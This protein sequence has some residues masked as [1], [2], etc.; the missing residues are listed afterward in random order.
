MINFR[1]HIVSLTAV[2]LALGIGLVLGTTFL[3]D[4]TVDELKDQLEG[5]ESDLNR[6]GRRNA[7]RAAKHPGDPARRFSLRRIKQK[8]PEGTADAPRRAR[9]RGAAARGGVH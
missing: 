5:L 4:A 7:G 6:E 9:H 3:D 8:N 2:L 1:F